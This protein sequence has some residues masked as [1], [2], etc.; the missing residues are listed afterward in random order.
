MRGRTPLAVGMAALVVLFL[1]LVWPSF[2]TVVDD[3]WISARYADH[4]A[5]GQGLVYNQGELVE[6]YTNLSW[7]LLLAAGLAL[8]LDLQALM[9]WTGLGF[10]LALLFVVLGL[11]AHL[12]P[13][14]DWTLLLAPGLV[15]VSPYV[16]MASTNGLETSMWLTA[17]VGACWAVLAAQERGRV[18]AGLLLGGLCLIRP[19]GFGVVALLGAWDLLRQRQ[20]LARWRTWSLPVAALVAPVAVTAWRLHTYGA[21]LP[22]TF[23]AKVSQSFLDKILDNTD[24]LHG[25]GPLW[26]LVWVLLLVLVLLPPRRSERLILGAVAAA[27]TGV[28]MTVHLWMPGGRLL[29]PGLVLLAALAPA[30]LFESPPWRRKLAVAMVL[31]A[32]VAL[33]PPLQA[34]ERALDHRVSVVPSSHSRVAAEHLA[35][36]LPPG[37]T[38]A[39]RDAGGFAYW[40]GTEVRVAEIHPRALTQPHPDHDKADY[41]S[42]LPEDVEVIVTTTRDLDGIKPKYSTER[43]LLRKH[44]KHYVHLGRYEHHPTRY[45][46]VYVRKDLDVPALPE[47]IV[48]N[49]AGASLAG[50]R[51]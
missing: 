40:L 31:A 33:L 4:L 23:Q 42:Y 1:L 32:L 45:Y 49:H 5:S 29:L 17:L 26:Y 11:A 3:A 8:G 47:E 10:G 51:R 15:A 13:R 7:T 44:G 21:W 50:G 6:G 25:Y 2:D 19:E 34:Y 14:R 37:S 9:V 38:V 36:H 48:L 27:L 41:D 12:S 30:V 20:H 24:Y 28:A 35:S 43:T 22:N 18:P 46:D 16:A 39:V